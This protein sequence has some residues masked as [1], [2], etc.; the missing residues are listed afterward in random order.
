[1]LSDVNELASNSWSLT[2]ESDACMYAHIAKY[3]V[4]VTN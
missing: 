1:M 4:N 2:A 3:I